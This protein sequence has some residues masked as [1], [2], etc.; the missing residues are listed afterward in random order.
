MFFCLMCGVFMMAQYFINPTG[1]ISC[2]SGGKYVLML[3]LFFIARFF[4]SLFGNF[5]FTVLM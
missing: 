5:F 4:A 2:L 3:S 1:C